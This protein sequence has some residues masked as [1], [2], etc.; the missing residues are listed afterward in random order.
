MKNIYFLLLIFVILFNSCEEL[1]Q[2]IVPGWSK[3]YPAKLNMEW[4]YN[5]IMVIEY[6]D[7]TGIIINSETRDL[8]NTIVRII[9]TD[10]TLGTYQNL[11]KFESFDIESSGISDYLWY[12]NSD[13]GLSA[14]AYSIAGS[15]Q[16]VVPKIQQK[17]YLTLNELLSLI[18]SP[19]LSIKTSKPKYPADSILYY[20][21]PRKVLAYPLTINKRWVEL[22]YPWYRERYV[23][24]SVNINFNG[25]ILYCYVIKVEW[26]GFN[27]EF[28][29]YVSLSNG[30]IKREIIADSIM[31]TSE[32]NPD[33]GSYGRVSS[34]SDLVRSN[35]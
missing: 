14:I 25:Q 17:H 20:E 21:V 24:K 7:T 3:K 19:E 26:S 18:N 6:Y 12:E 33:S 9:K 30:L 35:E 11:I 13:S 1:E 27:I 22:V 10:D 23:D 2:S 31:F 5:T 4:E 16:L 29:D 28:N 34:Y 8:G 32:T 15:S